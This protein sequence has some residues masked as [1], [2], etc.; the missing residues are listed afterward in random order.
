MRG[1]CA[2]GDLLINA[3]DS[4]FMLNQDG[5]PRVFNSGRCTQTEDH[6]TLSRRVL[7]VSGL[8]VV[9]TTSPLGRT[10]AATISP[11]VLL[12]ISPLNLLLMSFG[13]AASS[14]SGWH[15]WRLIRTSR[16]S[17]FG[18]GFV[19][20]GAPWNRDDQLWFVGTEDEMDRREDG[21]VA[22]DCEY[23]DGCVTRVAATW[24]PWTRVMR[25]SSRRVDHNLRNLPIST[26]PFPA[27][28]GI[29]P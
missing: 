3:I 12:P 24:T 11:V 10:R 28:S 13:V 9:S 18:T 25:I 16:S 21:G 7:A 15:C 14:R 6:S 5:E 26:C 4:V 23:W 22:A 27:D 29:A 20:V 17:L 2:P 19:S 8:S 1:Y